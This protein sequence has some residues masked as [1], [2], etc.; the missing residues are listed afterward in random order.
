MQSS[1]SVTFVRENERRG[2]TKTNSLFWWKQSHVSLSLCLFFLPFSPLSAIFSFSLYSPLLSQSLSLSLSFHSSPRFSINNFP[3]DNVHWCLEVS[4]LN[5]W[6]KL[7][8]WSHG[9]IQ[10]SQSLLQFSKGK[11]LAEGEEGELDLNWGAEKPRLRPKFTKSW[12]TFVS[13]FPSLR[14]IFGLKKLVLPKT[15]ITRTEKLSPSLLWL[16]ECP[17]I[18][19]F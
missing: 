19:N 1:N 14:I 5:H 6:M 9:F 11:P 8:S 18:R 3:D 4:Q 7:I 2:K 15:R 13:K 16:I 17:L 12:R 10:W